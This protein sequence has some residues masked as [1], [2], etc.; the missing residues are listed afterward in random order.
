MKE[1]G[2]GHI[3]NTA[4]VAGLVPFPVA[5]AYC[6]TKHAVVGLSLALRAEAADL[7]V[8]VGVICPGPVRTGIFDATEYIRVDKQTMLHNVSWVLQPPER[9]ARTILRAVRRDRSII[10]VT[11]YARL[12][13]WLYR[14]LPQALL[15]LS[16]RF[17][18]RLRPRLRT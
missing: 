17:Y 3:L 13:W 12:A 15:A 7:G 6:A 14:L 16:A 8:K 1:Q 18:A 2:G 11:T 4:C 10:T 9:C 5:A